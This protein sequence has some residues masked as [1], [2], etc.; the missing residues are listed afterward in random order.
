MRGLSIKACVLLEGSLKTPVLQMEAQREEGTYQRTHSYLLGRT[1]S[2]LLVLR[3]DIHPPRDSI[4]LRKKHGPINNSCLIFKPP[5]F[6]GR[7]H[8]LQD[9]VSVFRA[10]KMQP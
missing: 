4:S 1:S 5:T 8:G 3:G 9:E 10:I 6:L 7:V 2:G